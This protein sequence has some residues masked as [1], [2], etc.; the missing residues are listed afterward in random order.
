M[1]PSQPTKPGSEMQAGQNDDQ[2][3]NS[4]EALTNNPASGS[5]R[6]EPMTDIKP[7]A[8][9]SG[10][11]Q[12]HEATVQQADTTA[13]VV[14][15]VRA[16]SPKPEADGKL[17]RGFKF[18]S[19][20]PPPDEQ[21]TVSGDVTVDDNATGGIAGHEVPSSAKEAENEETADAPSE[22]REREAPAMTSE[23]VHD[24][25]SETTRAQ[26]AP[27]RPESKKTDPD[28]DVAARQWLSGQKHVDDTG[29][30]ASQHSARILDQVLNQKAAKAADVEPETKFDDVADQEANHTEAEP[31]TE[32]P[33]VEA[34]LAV[35]SAPVVEVEKDEG[36][37][38]KVDEPET[39]EPNVESG[40]EVQKDQVEAVPISSENAAE[41]LK[42]GEAAPMQQQEAEGE[43]AE[44][45]NDD[46]DE[47]P[48]DSAA[49]TP[50]GSPIIPDVA[51]AA[52]GGKKKK[53]KRKNKK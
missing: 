16:K 21:A 22:T 49:Q 34:S 13:D 43:G 11:S 2:S 7:P 24:A 37:A 42:L 45:A 8:T 29:D 6:E 51:A 9:T 50:A 39:P 36:E 44:E 1:P 25:P 35:E 40:I 48:A 38:V 14:T 46:E 18:P 12:A 10:S 20:S 17:D 23:P 53:N 4:N 5:K 47:T 3:Q 31:V 32:K 28:V 15:E 30:S 27:P 41:T 52:T 19:S 26:D 33:P